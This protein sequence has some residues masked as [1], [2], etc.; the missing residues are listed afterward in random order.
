MWKREGIICLL[1][2]WR[3]YDEEKQQSIKSFAVFR[4]SDVNPGED[5]HQQHGDSDADQVVVTFLF[6]SSDSFFIRIFVSFFGKA[7]NHIKFKFY[8]LNENI[9]EEDKDDKSEHCGCPPFLFYF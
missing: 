9:E 5:K 2:V 4:L 8:S 3:I 1:N 6:S 7:E